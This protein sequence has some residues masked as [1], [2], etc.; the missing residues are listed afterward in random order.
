[1]TLVRKAKST[2]YRE[3]AMELTIDEVQAK[4]LLKEIMVELIRERQDLFLELMVEAV[5]EVG[6]AN[7]IREGRQNEFVPEEEIKAI[8]ES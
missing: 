3:I 2:T 6:L 8:L 7:A 1:M 4:K 5:E